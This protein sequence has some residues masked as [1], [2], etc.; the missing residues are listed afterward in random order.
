MPNEIENL[1]DLASQLN[2]NL[3]AQQ[4]VLG[5]QQQLSTTNLQSLTVIR[6]LLRKE[7]ELKKSKAFV[8]LLRT[9][10]YGAYRLAVFDDRRM[11]FPILPEGR[12]VPTLE[13]TSSL[14][15]PGDNFLKEKAI[16]GIISYYETC[17]GL[18]HSIPVI[19]DGCTRE[20]WEYVAVGWRRI[21]SESPMRMLGKPKLPEYIISLKPEVAKLFDL[22]KLEKVILKVNDKS[23]GKYTIYYN[24][25]KDNRYI[26]PLSQGIEYLASRLNV[27]EIKRI[28][29]IQSVPPQGIRVQY[30]F[31]KIG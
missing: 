31:D 11:G 7:E 18:R 13:E 17:A 25:A 9:Y 14:Y 15:M 1:N 16:P 26:G 5:N 30:S 2:G 20:E 23:I 12:L 21:F 3:T 27:N 29:R 4:Q 10:G 28:M 22:A 8:D 19:G 6:S 24:D